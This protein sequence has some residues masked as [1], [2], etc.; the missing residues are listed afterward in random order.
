MKIVM[1]RITLKLKWENIYLNNTPTDDDG[2]NNIAFLKN[3]MIFIMQY[4]Y[5]IYF[6]YNIFFYWA[7]ADLKYKQLNISVE[8]FWYTLRWNIVLDVMRRK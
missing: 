4:I 7:D 3:N 5:F 8:K 6:F 1:D 2:Y